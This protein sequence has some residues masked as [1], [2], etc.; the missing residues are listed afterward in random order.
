MLKPVV[1]A[2]KTTIP[3]RLTTNVETGK[4]DSPGCS[5][6]I[7]TSRL[8]VISQIAL[9]KRRASVCHCPYSVEFTLGSCPQHL[10]SLRLITP[11]RRGT[12]HNHVLF[13]LI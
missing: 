10:K 9:P 5:K 8:S 6:T 13:R 7:S 1:P 11:W 3:P 12:L 4:V 2:Q